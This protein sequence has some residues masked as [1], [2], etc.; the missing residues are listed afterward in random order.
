[1]FKKDPT[2]GHP[3]FLQRLPQRMGQSEE[4][5]G[6][7]KRAKRFSINKIV[8]SI[9]VNGRTYACVREEDRPL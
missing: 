9:P 3:E 5:F 8:F 1:M 7:V 4:G 6:G 2:G